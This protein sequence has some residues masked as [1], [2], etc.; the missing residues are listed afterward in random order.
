MVSK[1]V[2][3]LRSYLYD[4]QCRVR[5]GTERSSWRLVNRGCPQ[6][7][8]LGPLL[9]NI[10]Q[11]DFIYSV[12]TGLTMYADDHQIYEIGKETCTVVTQLQ[13]SATLATNWYVPGQFVIYFS[14]VTIYL[15]AETN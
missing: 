15:S 11:N 6:G 10:F 1:A 3:M 2:D 5:I 13:Q 4:R 14:L 8:V 12:D 7:S 9:W